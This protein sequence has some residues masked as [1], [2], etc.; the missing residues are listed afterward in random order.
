MSTKGSQQQQQSR[1]LQMTQSLTENPAAAAS[2]QPVKGLSPKLNNTAQ[3]PGS[4]GRV[5]SQVN[6]VIPKY[7]TLIN[8]NSSSGGSTSA[9][10]SGEKQSSS[11]GA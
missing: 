3:S 2:K 7:G 9:E 6:N 10:S 11:V 5:I 8:N 1:N 4:L